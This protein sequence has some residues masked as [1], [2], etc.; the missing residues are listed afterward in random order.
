MKKI[1]KE[2]AIFLL[3]IMFP[4]W[5]LPVALAVTFKSFRES[6]LKFLRK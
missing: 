2:I 4:I 6:H 5:I 1:F 3:F